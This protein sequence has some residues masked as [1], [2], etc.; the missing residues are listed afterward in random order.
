MAESK[1][2]LPIAGVAVAFLTA[3][4]GSSVDDANLGAPT[5]DAP[6]Q[7]VVAPARLVATEGYEPSEEAQEPSINYDFIAL[8]TMNI[9]AVTGSCSN[10]ESHL[11]IESQEP[12]PSGT[13][14]TL[15]PA[16]LTQVYPSGAKRHSPVSDA[17][18]ATVAQPAMMFDIVLPASVQMIEYDVMGVS[19]WGIGQDGTNTR[20][21]AT[22]VEPADFSCL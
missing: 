12:L 2:F 8:I 11:L 18:R 16:K 5:L 14:I 10:G 6:R 1:W 9:V 20:S 15:T 19:A 13:V 4:S 3:C 7:T 17:F 22:L 21:N